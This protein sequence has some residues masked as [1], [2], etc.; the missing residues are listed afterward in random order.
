MRNLNVKMLIVALVASLSIWAQDTVLVKEVVVSQEFNPTVNDAFKISTSPK[1][2][3]PTSYSPNFEYQFFNFPL[4]TSYHIQPLKAESYLPSERPQVSQQNYVKGGFGNYSTLMGELFYNAYQ[5]KDQ[6][7][8]IFYRNRSSWGDVRLQ[9]DRKVDAPLL[10]NYGRVEFQ[11]RYRYAVLNSSVVFKRKAYEFYG[12][13]PLDLSLDYVYAD[14]TAL[15]LETGKQSLTNIG[16]DLELKSL[17]RRGSDLDYSVGLAFNSLSNDDKFSEN[18]FDITGLVQKS[19][20]KLEVGIDA[21]INAGFYGD[22]DV[23]TTRQYMGDPYYNIE[24]APFMAFEQKNWDLKL[25][26]KFELYQMGPIQEMLPAPVLD[27]NFDIVPK[28][29]KVYIQA[30]GDMKQNTYAQVTQL[31]PFVANDIVRKPTRKALDVAAGIVGHPTSSLSMTLGVNYQIIKDQL[32]F[33]NEMVDGGDP[34]TAGMNYTNRFVAEYD[35][36]NLLAF[37]GELNYNNYK[38][39]SASAAFDYYS[40]DLA[41]LP[42][43]WNLPEYK[44]S[45]YGHYDVTEQI[46]LKG[47]FEFMP[48]R[49]VKVSQS[50]DVDYTPVTYDLS[51]SGEYKFRDNLSFFADLNNILGSKYYYFNGYPAYRLNVLLG[52]TF[53]F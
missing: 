30:N 42:E 53:R 26:A 33:V 4:R 17:E 20:D 8:N 49:A 9:D 41:N 15:A 16:F 3:K 32:F 12:Y 45:L 37:H 44:I 36:N 14:S 23:S 46:L 13:H 18:Q 24:L 47:T 39:W 22:A 34:A 50:N 21:A 52:A 28:Y 51:M 7:V 35:D 6:N 19:L 2:D 1:M 40:Y 5:S 29:F 27:F 38:Q 25:G 43:A 48:E 31:N 10:S 11:K